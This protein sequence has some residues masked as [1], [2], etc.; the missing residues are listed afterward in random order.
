M[1]LAGAIDAI[2]PVQAGVEPLRAN[3]ARISAPPACG[4]ARHRKRG[5]RLRCRNSRP[6]SPNRSRC[7][8]GGRTPAWRNARRWFRGRSASAS[9]RH[10]NSGTPSSGTGFR[11]LGTPALRKYFCASTSQATWLQLSGTSMPSW[12]KT[13][14]PS[15]LRISLLRLAER[16]AF[17]GRMI[18]DREMTAECAWQYPRTMKL[19]G[20]SPSRGHRFGDRRPAAGKGEFPDGGALGVRQ[21]WCHER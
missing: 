9:L 4:R 18:L 10:R 6:S 7:R 11:P 16:D 19:D 14:E 17:V 3:W 13:T 15:G 5:R 21:I 8:P 2:G 1:A 20:P 12:W